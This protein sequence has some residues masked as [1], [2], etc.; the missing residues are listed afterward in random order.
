[1]PYAR[2]E[3]FHIREGWLFKG[4]AAICERPHIFLADDASDRLG[5]GKNMVRALRFWMIATGIAEE[6]RES[7]QTYQRLTEPF[8][9]LVWEHDPYLEEEGTL[10]LIHYHLVKDQGGA[11]TWYWFFN[12]FSQPVFDQ[13]I[14]I[15]A[16]HSWVIGNESKSISEKSLK[17][18]FD[19]LVRTY[20]PD[21][22]AH[23]PEDLIECPLAQLGLI[24]EADNGRARR[25]RLMRPNPDRIHPMIFLYVLLRWHQDKKHEAQQVGVAEALR[26]PVNVGRV[27]NLGIAGLSLCLNRLSVE[28]PDL[29]VHLTRSTGLDQLTLPT[30]LSD[31]VL[32]RYFESTSPT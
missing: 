19:C 23:S 2:H 8:G 26:E 31:Q 3:T 1:M 15:D 30:A 25:Y 12:H 4:M 32:N 18:D 29:T 9:R 22:K 24:A 6:Y 14:F 10:W 28:Y 20:L 5:L 27:F 16:L 7:R 17:R 13:A 11:T 21:R